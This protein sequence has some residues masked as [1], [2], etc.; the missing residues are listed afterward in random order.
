MGGRTGTPDKPPYNGTAILG[1]RDTDNDVGLE[2]ATHLPRGWP[3]TS[4][5][6][7]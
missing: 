5:L 3:S 1:W 2:I 7:F 4:D 6:L